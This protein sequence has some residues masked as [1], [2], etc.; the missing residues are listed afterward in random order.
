M[1]C[2]HTDQIADVTPGTPQGCQEC[3]ESGS[4]WVHLRVC[5]TCGHVGCCD[6]SPNQHATRHYRATKHPIIQSYE[7][8]ENWVYCYP[9]DE[10][11]GHRP[12]AWEQ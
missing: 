8:G 6:Q 5:L 11:V 1:T 9:D 2:S 10:L 3:L 12:K 4:R 7:S